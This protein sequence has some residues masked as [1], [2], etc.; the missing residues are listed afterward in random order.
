MREKEA[1]GNEI[2]FMQDNAPAHRSKKTTEFLQA[3]NISPIKW[4]ALSPDLN[5]IEHCWNWM[6]DYLQQT[7]GDRKFTSAELYEKVQEA[8]EIAV[9]DEK[10]DRLMASM[11]QRCVDVIA[12]EG[13]YTRW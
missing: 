7:Y 8:W 13:G 3:R 10:L 5:P 9:A 4:P 11:H 6:K 2:L 1:E 12:A